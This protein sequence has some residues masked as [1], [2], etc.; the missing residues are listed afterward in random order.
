M[1][2]FTT[3]KQ[4]KIDQYMFCE[5]CFTLTFAGVISW[6]VYPESGSF[7]PLVSNY[8]KGQKETN[9]RTTWIIQSVQKH[10]WIRILNAKTYSTKWRI[11]KYSTVYSRLSNR[12]DVEG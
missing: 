6:T 12:I 8:S 10:V 4:F 1:K 11:W 5:I 9:T 3:V 7:C 2:V